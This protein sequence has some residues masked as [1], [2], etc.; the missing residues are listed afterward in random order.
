MV[1]GSGVPCRSLLC[2]GWTWFAV[3]RNSSLEWSRPLTKPPLPW[4]VA[5]DISSRGEKNSRE[6]NRSLHEVVG[7]Q[8]GVAG[9][10]SEWNFWGKKGALPRESGKSPGGW[11]TKP[12][13]CFVAI[14]SPSDASRLEGGAGTGGAA[15]ASGEDGGAQGECT[16]CRR[17]VIK[18]P[19]SKWNSSGSSEHQHS[20]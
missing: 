10:A 16:A 3:V 5:G 17:G 2:N 9:Q 7:K 15:I 8:S 20:R 14:S 12:V 19:V 11:S 6:R 4:A 13:I 18:V 1:T